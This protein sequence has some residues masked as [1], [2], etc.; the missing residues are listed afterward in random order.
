MV[1]CAGKTPVLAAGITVVQRKSKVD[2]SCDV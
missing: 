1:V 2:M